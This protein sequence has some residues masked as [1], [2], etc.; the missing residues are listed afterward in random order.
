[1]DEH[2]RA[3]DKAFKALNTRERTEQEL[4]E[5]LERRAIERDVIDDVVA[6]LRDEGL[7]DDAGYAQRFADDRRLIDRWGSE[8]IARDLARRGIGV[9]EIEGA[10]SAVERGDELHAA[11]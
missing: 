8:R 4:R 1:M 7:V 6:S 2:R 5:F 3:L 9:E 10:L 11:V